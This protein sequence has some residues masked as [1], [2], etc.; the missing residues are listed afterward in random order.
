M[1]SDNAEWEERRRGELVGVSDLFCFEDARTFAGREIE[2]LDT[3][4]I[5]SR[6]SDAGLDEMI[7]RG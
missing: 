2:L 3:G 7:S 5:L 1:I 6:A 4:I